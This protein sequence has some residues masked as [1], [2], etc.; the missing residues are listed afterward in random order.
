MT[1]KVKSK[2]IFDFFAKKNTNKFQSNGYDS[3]L[4]FSAAGFEQQASRSILRP[5]MPSS[6]IL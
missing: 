6:Y 3:I 2:E 5:L 1:K 4:A